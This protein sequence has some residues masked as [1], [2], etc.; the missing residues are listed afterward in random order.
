MVQVYNVDEVGKV[1]EVFLRSR[2]DVKDLID[3]QACWLRS[4][5]PVMS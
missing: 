4:L 5:I 2:A 1:G 3:L